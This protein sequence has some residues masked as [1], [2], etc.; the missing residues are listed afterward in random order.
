MPLVVKG[1]SRR[2]VDVGYMR[3]IEPQEYGERT[4]RGADL[5]RLDKSI[6]YQGLDDLLYR[7]RN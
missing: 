5:I 4:I 2:L 7:L 3:L 1:S 6:V